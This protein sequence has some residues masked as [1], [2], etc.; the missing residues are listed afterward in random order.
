MRIASMGHAVFA[1]VL[2]GL[3]ILGLLQPDLATFAR[4]V[5][6][7]MPAR[8]ALDY[9]CSCICLA[10]GIGLFGRRSAVYAARL[11]LAYFLLCMLLFNMRIIVL[12]PLLE[13]A[14]QNW[15]Q[16]GVMVAAAWVLY[17]WFATDRD[18]QYLGF[19]TGERGLR[20][21]RVFYGLSLIGFGFSHFAYLDNTT[22]LVPAW[23]PGPVFW[24]YSTGVAYLAAG[25]GV[26]TG[27]LAR[28]AVSLSAL[29]MGLFLPV[30]WLPVLMAGNVTAFRWGE[31]IG[32]VALTAGAWAV[33]DSYNGMPWFSVRGL[34]RRG[35]R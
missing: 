4:Q 17:V 11:L 12:H 1:A 23:L 2:I 9:L 14:Y 26:L 19:A 21:A 27:V 35:A 24:A 3:G 28:L 18:R 32:T 33:A 13:V 8:E 31:I 15:G 6:K 25:V 22:T 29:Q 7:W 20:I 5:P 10:S 34:S 30:V 16:A